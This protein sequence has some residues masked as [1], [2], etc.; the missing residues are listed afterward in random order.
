MAAPPLALP[1][2]PPVVAEAPARPAA[3]APPVPADEPPPPPV[4]GELGP[5][6]SSPQALTNG[7]APRTNNLAKPATEPTDVRMPTWSCAGAFQPVIKAVAS[8]PL[9]Q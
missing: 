2:A 8:V 7:N 6:A 9:G 1:A 4:V 5:A 3:D